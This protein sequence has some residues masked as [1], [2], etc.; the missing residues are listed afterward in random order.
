MSQAE[1]WA[2]PSFD[3]VIRQ[4]CPRFCPTV[5]NKMVKDRIVRRGGADACA[6]ERWILAGL[7]NGP[8]ELKIPGP[9]RGVLKFSTSEMA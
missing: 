8:V 4:L 7:E 2:T 5:R 9:E 6:C 1:F 3:D